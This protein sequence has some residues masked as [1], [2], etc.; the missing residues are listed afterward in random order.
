MDCNHELTGA[1]AND[2]G[3]IFERGSTGDNAAFIWD[4]S[5]DKFKLGTTT[6]VPSDTGFIAVTK[7]TLI[8]DLN[9]NAD[10]ASKW[11]TARTVDLYRW[12]NW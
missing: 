1:N 8:A 4:E 9:G 11:L 12:C 10:T 2:I 3:F 6:A 7:G 5:D